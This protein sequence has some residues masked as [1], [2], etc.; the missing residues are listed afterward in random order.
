MFYIK[1]L[2][3]SRQILKSIYLN[4]SVWYY[5][6][7]T[8]TWCSFEA[9]ID[10]HA[11]VVSLWQWNPRTTFASR[12]RGKY[13]KLHSLTYHLLIEPPWAFVPKEEKIGSCSH[14]QSQQ[15]DLR[16]PHGLWLGKLPK[17]CTHA[18]S[19]HMHWGFGGQS[20]VQTQTL[21]RLPP[22]HHHLTMNITQ[23]ALSGRESRRND[24]EKG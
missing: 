19:S 10:E 21:G 16:V 8:R 23:E 17:S 13:E 6:Y 12:R 1:S 15:G 9:T 3:G 4:Y 20:Q 24:S 22:A 18:L 5:E 7:V 11:R 2:N 14:T